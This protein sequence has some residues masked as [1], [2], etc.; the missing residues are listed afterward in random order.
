MAD[1]LKNATQADGHKLA[2][3]WLV[4]IGLTLW[5]WRDDPD[6][7]RHRALSDTA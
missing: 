6:R 1:G 4:I 5:S 2:R 7:T 3:H